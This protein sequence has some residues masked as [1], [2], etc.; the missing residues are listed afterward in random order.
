[1]SKFKPSDSPL[2]P[3]GGVEIVPVDQ[4]HCSCFEE[5]YGGMH[6]FT[7]MDMRQNLRKGI[8]MGA[9][10]GSGELDLGFA[11]GGNNDAF[12]QKTVQSSIEFSKGGSDRSVNDPRALKP[13]KTAP[14]DE[15]IEAS[16][17]K[18]V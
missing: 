12:Y 11:G 16:K 6:E 17:K 8:A 3:G 4:G 2:P 10:S 5:A 14:Q 13:L 7:Q 1:M 18:K 9:G 15:L